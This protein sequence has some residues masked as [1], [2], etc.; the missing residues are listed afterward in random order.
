MRLNEQL[1]PYRNRVM[2]LQDTKVIFTDQKIPLV[3]AGTG[4]IKKIAAL[5]SG[6]T[7][8]S[9]EQFK[10]TYSSLTVSEFMS[11]LAHAEDE[12]DEVDHGRNGES[13]VISSNSSSA[14][15]YT[16][17]KARKKGETARRLLLESG[18]NFL[19][20]YLA[21]SD[22]TNR[23][24]ANGRSIIL[25][26][27][28][29]NFQK[30]IDIFTSLE[31]GTPF[32]TETA[33]WVLLPNLESKLAEEYFISVLL[34]GF[35]SEIPPEELESVIETNKDIVPGFNSYTALKRRFVKPTNGIV[36]TEIYRLD[37]RAVKMMGGSFIRSNTILSRP[38]QSRELLNIALASVGGIPQDNYLETV[39][40]E[41]MK[42]FA[43][44]YNLEL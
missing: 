23:I 44:L 12:K 33:I 37:G 8:L 27:P 18:V 26:K 22:S 7:L 28:K 6:G 32:Y 20:Y 10:S 17:D 42:S 35:N 2:A 39:P 38:N 14:H 5:A 29:D 4:L 9:E 34:G 30:T 3:Y 24:G 15:W 40:S 19:P 13:A 43:Q 16:L 31:E 25:N 11:A 21:F 1:N 36:K 41:L